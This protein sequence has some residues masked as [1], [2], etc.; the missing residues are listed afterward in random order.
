MD[1]YGGEGE[2]KVVQVI[3]SSRLKKHLV[4]T[5]MDQNASIKH[6]VGLN[7]NF[8]TGPQILRDG[9]VDHALHRL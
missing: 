8:Y 9:P 6:S 1:N 2:K 7:N 4:W 3:D 5:K